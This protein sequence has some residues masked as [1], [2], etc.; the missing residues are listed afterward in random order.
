MGNLGLI[1][2]E[3]LGIAVI[4]PQLV[5]TVGQLAKSVLSAMVLG[6]DLAVM[7]DVQYPR[8]VTQRPAPASGSSPKAAISQRSSTASRLRAL[9]AS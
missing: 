3:T 2:V 4:G 8:E 1:Q 9:V 5:D 6:Q 7:P